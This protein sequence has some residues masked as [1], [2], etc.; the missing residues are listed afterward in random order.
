MKLPECKF[1]YKSYKYGFYAEKRAYADNVVIHEL[2]YK[3]QI[4]SLV[5]YIYIYILTKF[6]PIMSAFSDDSLLL[7]QDTNQFFI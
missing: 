3:L 2:G 7:D 5:L 4:N 1:W 6:Q